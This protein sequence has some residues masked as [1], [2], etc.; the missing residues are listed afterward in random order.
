MEDILQSII[1][2]FSGPKSSHKFRGSGFIAGENLV[3][4]CA[5]VLGADCKVG[6]AFTF[7]IEGDVAVRSAAVVAISPESKF[8]LAI[9]TPTT[10][11]P[12][13]RALP[14]A[15]AE[16][17]RGHRFSIFGYPQKGGFTGLHG[18]GSILGLVRDD[19]GRL[20][21]QLDSDQITHGFSGAPIW[22]EEL[23]AV[24]GVLSRGIRDDEIG[25]PSFAIPCEMLEQFYPGLRVETRESPEEKAAYR[26]LHQL[27]SPPP[28]FI[29]RPKE[30]DELRAGFK[31]GRAAAISGLTGM[32]GIGKTVLGLVIAHELV[33]DYPDAQIFLDLKGT[34]KAPLAPAEA[35]RHAI[36]SFEP[37]ADLRALDEA[38]LAVRKPCSSGTTPAAPNR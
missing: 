6:D 10:P 26:A 3:I 21:L 19:E 36:H 15:F 23:E 35:M 31:D 4:T 5:H 20:A 13:N 8:D 16:H 24:V 37:A 27:P 25:Q 1:G 30:L 2:L 9:L 29:Q 33:K 17:S 12:K 18:E 14:L 22:D 34:S 38:Q 28:D 32:G 11:L 7:Q